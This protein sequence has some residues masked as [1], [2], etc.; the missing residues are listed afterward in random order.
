M[1]MA[2]RF[3]MR[4]YS[5]SSF[6]F[7]LTSTLQTFFA[8][9]SNSCLAFSSRSSFMSNF[10]RRERF[11]ADTSPHIPAFFMQDSSS[12]HPTSPDKENDKDV[13]SFTFSTRSLRMSCDGR[14]GSGRINHRQAPVTRRLFSCRLKC[15]YRA[16]F[17]ISF[18]DEEC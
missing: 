11:S 2:V 1:I 6:F 12:S 4:Q 5:F 7:I 16:S 9:C 10:A 17:V 18:L 13:S 15:H 14:T 3:T 8:Y